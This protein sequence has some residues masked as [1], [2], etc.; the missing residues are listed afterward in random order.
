MERFTQAV[1]LA[2]NCQNWYA[3]LSIALTLPDICGGLENPSNKNRDRYVDWFENYLG[4][5]YSKQE[6]VSLS[7]Y[8]C[9]LLRCSYLHAGGEGINNAKIEEALERFHFVEPEGRNSV[10]F[11]QI[12]N[13][14]VLHVDRFCEDMCLGVEKWMEEIAKSRPEVQERFNKLLTI[15][16][17]ESFFYLSGV[18]QLD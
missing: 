17:M 8:D 4:D 16:P 7:G 10:H 11:N 13:A 9:Y 3:A 15:Y 2:I 18:T 5:K 6:R 12:D 14:L 1:R